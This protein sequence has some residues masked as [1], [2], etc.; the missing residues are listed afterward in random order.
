MGCKKIARD[1]YALAESP[2]DP[3]APFVKEALQVIDQCLDTHRYVRELSLHVN[4]RS[5]EK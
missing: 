2:S 5:V 1:V 4:L 3:L